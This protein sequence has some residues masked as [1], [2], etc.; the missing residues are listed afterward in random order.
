MV[1][2][3]TQRTCL[4]T[5]R[6]EDLQELKEML[7]NDEIMKWTGIGIILEE[8]KCEELLNKWVQ[9]P[10]VWAVVNLEN[11]KVVGWFMLKETS[12]KGIPELG[13]M[14]HQDSW[15]R[16]LATEV[17]FELIK[18]AREQLK[19]PKV[20]A[21]TDIKNIG[22]QAVLTKIEMQEV[23]SLNENPKQK[24]FEIKL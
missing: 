11:E 3:H 10:F 6:L 23:K 15:G 5:F 21:S 16:G 4:R 8:E 14:I 24:H 18:Y 2:I 17:S 20:I 12:Q 1:L 7:L 9:D 22:S 13:F 19:V